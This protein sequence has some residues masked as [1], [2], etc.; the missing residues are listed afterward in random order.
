MAKKAKD[1]R[2]RNR[3]GPPNHLM[4]TASEGVMI[5]S[6]IVQYKPSRLI[7]VYPALICICDYQLSLGDNLAGSIHRMRLTTL[8]TSAMVAS[9]KYTALEASIDFAD[10][11]KIP[12]T[13]YIVNEI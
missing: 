4:P 5:G 13:K 10:P 12:S 8:T 7:D 6:W 2:V 3:I 9:T 11:V 1:W